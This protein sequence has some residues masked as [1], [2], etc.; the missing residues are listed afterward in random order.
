M[1]TFAEESKKTI[2]EKV[3]LVTV[4]SAKPAK[5]FTLLSGSNYYRDV[6]FFV[7][8]VKQGLVSLTQVGSI[9]ALVAGSFFY[10]IDEKRL[11][12]RTIG[13]VNPKT[14]EIIIFYRHFFSNRPTILPYD[15]GSGKDVEWLPYVTSIGSIGQQ[16]DEQST[17]IVLE[18]SSSIDLLNIGYFDNLYD[19]HIWE[20]K[21][22][23]FYA[24]FA[25]LA[26]TEA[27]QIFEGTIESK[28]FAIDKISFKVKDFIFKL[29]DQ[30][31]HTLFSSSDG[32]VSDAIIG[33][34]KRRIYGQAK[35]VKCIGT[36]LL[37][38]GY[39]GSGTITI[40]T[41]L[42]N[43]SGTASASY[44]SNDVSGT[45]SGTSGT[46]TV[47][48][49]G[50]NFTSVFSPNQKI[51]ITNGLAIYNYTVFSVNS[52]TSI[53]LTSDISVSFSAFTAKNSSLGNNKVYGVGTSFLAQLQQGSSVTFTNGTLSQN[54]KVESIES[55]VELTLSDFITASFSVYNIINNDQKNNKIIG[56][57]TSFITQLSVGDTVRFIISGEEINAKI[58]SIY[59]NT[60]ALLSESVTT[61]V[62][63][64][65]FTVIPEVSYYNRNRVWNVAGHKLREPTTTITQVKAN[66]RFV[67]AS[68]DDL[69]AGD[70]VLV[71]GGFSTIRRISGSELVTETEVS[72]IP[73]IGATVKKI[74]IQ[75]VYFG[76]Q[77]LIYNRDW[78]YSNTTEAKI[79][80]DTDAEF[81]IAKEKILGVSLQFTS[82]SRS[83]TTNS[84]ADFRSILSP[85]DYIK[86]NSIVSGESD[87]YEIIDVKE[88]EIVLR[89]AFTGSTEI[90]S[91]LYKKIDYIKDDSL[92]SANCLGMEVSGQWIK[93]PSDAVR[94]IIINDSGFTSINEASFTQAKADCNYIISLVTP[95]EP[96]GK[97]EK[98]RDVITKINESVFGSLYGSS[99]SN[100]SYSILNSTKPASPTIIKDDDII[101]FDASSSG[102]FYNNITVNYRPFTDHATGERTTEVFEYNS[103]F[104]DKYIGV[105]NTLEKNIYLYEDDKAIIIAQRLAFFNQLSNTKLTLKGKMNFFLNQ[106]NDKLLVNFD[107]LF[108]RF[109]GGD[110]RKYAIITGIKRSQTEVEVVLSDLGNVYNRVP[111]IAPNTAPNYSSA[112]NDEKAQW[113]YICD[114]DTLT[115]DPTS[116]ENLLNNLIG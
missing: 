11:Y 64:K 52:A 32:Y 56:T 95:E 78:T 20:N 48:G 57:G 58:D 91:S 31:T 50:T 18:S 82:G 61:P 71:N 90:I 41:T 27:Q 16:L 87:W 93:T 65:P 77:E 89:T 42:T 113:G 37:L 36:D 86:K 14:V 15:L 105:N 62:V 33:T 10:S 94:H 102:N 24:W 29:R 69:F 22:V 66:N 6:D 5:I 67:L 43:L 74:P 23:K 98:I 73:S 106:V 108:K 1:S 2:S 38:D 63:N 88:Q 99:S 84:I 19:T 112:S 101:S 59:S 35:Q 39:A 72:P 30:I 51:R 96:G 100:I 28:D 47:T 79:Q 21:T 114:N 116:E 25:G 68:T 4:D 53:T 34:P 83:V 8:N 3:T 13:S 111:S 92:I 9:G 85:R 104:S 46:R 115:P 55:D 26:A 103:G 70:R 12:L 80:I 17:G 107:R 45:V 60:S 49:S 76:F 110:N 44:I 81:N 54:Y 97:P 7:T 109:G 75:N 40:D